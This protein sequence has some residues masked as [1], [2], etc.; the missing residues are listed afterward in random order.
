M[1]HI[2][3]FRAKQIQFVEEQD[4]P[5]EQELKEKLIPIFIPRRELK[6]AYLARVEFGS[7]AGQSVALCLRSKLREDHGLLN[8]IERTFNALFNAEAHLDI[9]FL[10]EEQLEPLASVCKPFYVRREHK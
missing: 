1:N 4:G 9:V 7:Q 8:E 3:E 10:R 5:A 2:E 6:E